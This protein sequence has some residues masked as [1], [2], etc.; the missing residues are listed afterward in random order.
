MTMK[1]PQLSSVSHNSDNNV[2]LG[3]LLQIV[4]KLQEQSEEGA[5]R[6]AIL[7]TLNELNTFAQRHFEAQEKYLASIGAPEL[8]TRKS[9]NHKV[10]SQLAD[11]TEKF[12]SSS[13]AIISSRFFQFIQICL[14]IQLP[15]FTNDSAA[16]DAKSA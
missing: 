12:K 7:I 13:A 11:H 4:E 8:K 10:L 3:K 14:S 1:T 15:L 6:S 16:S 9:Q 2:E 5:T